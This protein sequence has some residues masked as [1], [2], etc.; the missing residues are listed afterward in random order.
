MTTVSAVIFLVSPALTLATVYIV[1]LAEAGTYGMAIA[2]LRASRCD[3]RGDPGGRPPDRRQGP[4]GR[5]PRRGAPN[6]GGMSASAP[7]VEFRNVT[8]RFGTFVA[9]DRVSFVDLPPR[10]W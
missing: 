5:Q 7:V 6:G 1:N 3:A 10:R 8:K 2:I 4:P 9:V